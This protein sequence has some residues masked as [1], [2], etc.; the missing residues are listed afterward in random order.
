MTRSVRLCVCATIEAVGCWWVEATRSQPDL[1]RITAYCRDTLVVPSSSYRALV[2]MRGRDERLCLAATIPGLLFRI[3]P[4]RATLVAQGIRT[5]GRTSRTHGGYR[6][7]ESKDGGIAARLVP[8]IA[9]RGLFGASDILASDVRTTLIDIDD[10]QRR[11]Q[12]KG[13]GNGSSAGYELA[14]GIRGSL[15]LGGGW[16]A[17]KSQTILASIRGVMRSRAC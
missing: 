10:C 15:V 7:H 14:R 9:A 4:R 16:L 1:V 12:V 13:T 8:I 2:F 6:A 5:S 11:G 3:Q 17:S